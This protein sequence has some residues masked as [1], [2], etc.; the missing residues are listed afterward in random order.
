MIESTAV[1]LGRSAFSG[2][3]AR[4]ATWISSAS[5]ADCWLLP[6]CCSGSFSTTSTLW[7]LAEDAVAAMVK[8]VNIFASTR[9]ENVLSQ[10]FYD[11][12]LLSGVCT[13][14]VNWSF[15]CLVIR[16]RWLAVPETSPRRTRNSLLKCPDKREVYIRP[17]CCE[18]SCNHGG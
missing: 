18:F 6:S 13:V 11:N 14:H 4:A 17:R 10:D 16:S 3:S 8:S 1:R 12:N 2:L 15:K 5:Y 7:V 9:A